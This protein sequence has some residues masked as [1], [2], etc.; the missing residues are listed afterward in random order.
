VKE[1]EIHQLK[2]GLS[3]PI[4]KTNIDFLDDIPSNIKNRLPNIGPIDLAQGEIDLSFITGELISYSCILRN[5][6]PTSI[7]SIDL[8]DN[9]TDGLIELSV[10][11]SYTN[12]Y[13]KKLS[14]LSGFTGLLAKFGIF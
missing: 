5:A 4:Y 1:V 10:S 2:K 3:L 8:A 11:L 7:V 13:D 12:W 6:F 9:T 14:A